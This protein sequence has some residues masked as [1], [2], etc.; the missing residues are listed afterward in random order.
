MSAA[1][2]SRIGLPL[3]SVSCKANNSVFSSIMSAILFKIVARS[4]ALVF[5]QVLKASLA[6]FTAASTSASVASIKVANASPF[7]GLCA[8]K[9]L[10]SEPSV[11]SPLINKP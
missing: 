11:H 10:P 9:V 7:A 1:R 3:S 6:A 5:F 2:V 4:V 8:V